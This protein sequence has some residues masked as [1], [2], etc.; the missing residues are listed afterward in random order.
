MKRGGGSYGFL[1]LGFWL[2][3]SVVGFD[4][5]SCWP[6]AEGYSPELLA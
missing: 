2:K 6:L 1:L 5:G 3:S 4:A